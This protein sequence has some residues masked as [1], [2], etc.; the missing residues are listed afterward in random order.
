MF[1]YFGQTSESLAV[2]VLKA[3]TLVPRARPQR[4]D[5]RNEIQEMPSD[6]RICR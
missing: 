3:S 6:N 4:M 5:R 1:R 2:N